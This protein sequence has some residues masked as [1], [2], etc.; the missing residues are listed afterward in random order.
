ML[1]EISEDPPHPNKT[2]SYMLY[3]SKKTPRRPNKKHPHFSSFAAIDT[4]T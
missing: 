2:M 3:S 1:P 4:P